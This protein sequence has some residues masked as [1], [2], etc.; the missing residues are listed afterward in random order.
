MGEG[1]ML[2]N[3][4]HH[5][6]NGALLRQRPHSLLRSFMDFILD[7]VQ[8]ERKLKSTRLIVFIGL[9]VPR[10][11]D[12][13]YSESVTSFMI[14]KTSA[15]FHFGIAN[16]GLYDYTIMKEKTMLFVIQ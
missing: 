5:S 16:V 1:Q 8:M 12:T 10:L 6:W 9:R 13:S 15:H 14:A 2:Y 4:M 3:I 11:R 7:D